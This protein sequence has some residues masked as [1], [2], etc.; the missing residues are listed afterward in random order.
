MRPFARLAA[1]AALTTLFSGLLGVAGC[2]QSAPTAVATA[3]PSAGEQAHAAAA[4][5]P[6]AAAE[7]RVQN[8]DTAAFN[9]AAMAD[10]KPKPGV[11]LLDVR[12]PGE[13]AE[14]HLPGA[15]VIDISD[16]AFAT[17]AA[18]LPK[19]KPVYVYCRSG[20][21]SA[22]AAGQL[23]TMGFPAVYNLSGGIMGWTRAGLPT[24]R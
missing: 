23:A 5:A 21:R 9:S 3:A 18:A 24:A 1:P 6:A 10:G 13:V 22:R 11:T 17:K 8:L 15:T 19:D 16:P 2:Q 4:T 20:A 14:G 12:T 7:V